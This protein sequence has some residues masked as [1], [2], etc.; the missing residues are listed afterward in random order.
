MPK[1]EMEVFLPVSPDQ[2][3][4]D[5]FLMSGVNYELSPI[6]KM[7][8][9]E[10]W[11]S[12]SIAHWP[13]NEYVFS[14]IIFL[15]GF[16]PIDLHRFKLLSVN[17]NGFKESSKTL[18]NS[19][20]SHERNILKSDS[21]ATVRDVVYYKSKIGFLGSLLKPIYHSIFV[22]RH[23]RLKLKYAKIS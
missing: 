11:A 14:S 12:K 6:V 17:S 9:P 3:S 20:W 7:S 23:N 8:A 18:F 4:S 10:E 1:F 2:L 16:I 15:F 21:G 13:V 22:H 19:V 5:L